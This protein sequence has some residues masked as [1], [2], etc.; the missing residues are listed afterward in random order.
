M[1]EKSG[2]LPQL[3]GARGLAVLV[4]ISGHLH[5][6]PGFVSGEVAMEA[7]FGLSGFLITGLL[8][9]EHRRRGR[10]DLPY[11]F[12]RRALRLLPA[13]W[14]FLGTWLAIVLLLGHE[15]WMTTVP[16]SRFGGA[17]HVAPALAGVLAAVAYVSNWMMALH[18]FHGQVALGHL[19]SLAVEEQFYLIWAPLLALVLA[20]RSSY[21]LPATI[22]MAA[23]SL[24]EP[25]WLWDH[26]RGVNHVYFGTDTRAAALLVG[27]VAAQLWHRGELSKLFDGVAGAML[28]GGCVAGMVAAGY[29]MHHGRVPVEWLSG[30][31]V[32]SI[33]GPLAV[34]GLVVRGAKPAAVALSGPWIT[35]VGRRS[36]GLYLW[37]YPWVTWLSGIGP[38]RY[39]LVL[40]ASFACAE[41]S[42]RLV[43]RRAL[44]VKTR[45]E[46]ADLSSPA[47]QSEPVV[48]SPVRAAT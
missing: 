32:G 44:T 45:F 27:A 31:T 2:R 10:I 37:H 14:L 3:D 17:Q 26:G 18:L 30:W 39:P 7:F 38:A 9:A 5:P 20:R 43:E 13:L 4:V 22:G 25:L 1:S 35:Y 12:A 23:L 36:Y 8:L 33:A 24:A 41:A 11:F 46:R 28:M 21:A 19:W 16:G 47:A 42:W 15:R 34:A 48:V 29:L 6:W 40:L